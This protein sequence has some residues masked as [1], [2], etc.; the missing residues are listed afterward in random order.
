MKVKVLFLILSFFSLNYLVCQTNISTNEIPKLDYIQF[1]NQKAICIK[2][3]D[4]DSISDLFALKEILKD[5]QIILLGESCHGVKEFNQNKF[6][7]IKFLVENMGFDII[8]FESPID[9]CAWVNS[10][11]KTLD[12]L[13]ILKKSIYGIWH[14]SDNLKLSSYLKGNNIQFFGFDPQF[15]K[16]SINCYN[17]FENLGYLSNLQ[18][19]K[20]S[21]TDNDIYNKIVSKRGIKIFNS[22]DSFNIFK[23]S[24]LNLYSQ[25]SDSIKTIYNVNPTKELLIFLKILENRITYIQKTFSNNIFSNVSRDSIMAS[26][27][28]WYSKTIYSNHKIIIWAHNGH[29]EKE[30][31]G[32]NLFKESYMGKLLQETYQN[33]LYSVGFYMYQG[34]INL[35]N[36]VPFNV[37]KN[38]KNSLENILHQVKCERFFIDI[39]QE[40]K[41][42]N[43]KWLFV[44]TSTLNTGGYNSEEKKIIKRLYDGIFFIQNVNLNDYL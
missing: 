11:K 38:S 12:S 42:K 41:R 8:G 17:Y 7:L 3:V 24:V 39:S 21:N 44:K 37:V 10:S 25:I 4:S 15:D 16:S 28:E 35:N 23:S 18:K 43:N 40:K 31:D 22:P 33:K 27:I 9:R 32:N 26:N 34:K 30:S 29:I 5:K 36:R 20:L 13:E 2:N 1:V 6:R 19:R 14:T